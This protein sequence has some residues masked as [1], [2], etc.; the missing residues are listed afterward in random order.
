[1]PTFNITK[2]ADQVKWCLENRPA[3]KSD[4]TKLTLSVWRNFHETEFRS[5][6]RVC[7]AS[8]DVDIPDALKVFGRSYE[9]LPSSESCSRVR[10]KFN[11][12]GM[13]LPDRETLSARRLKQYD[14]LDWVRDQPMDTL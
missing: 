7:L 14:V 1:M 9:D 3:T 11:E 2:T 4:D 12:K 6:V 5:L 10:R 8:L 13:Y